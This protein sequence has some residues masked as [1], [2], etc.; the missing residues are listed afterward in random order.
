M[1]SKLI[2]IFL[3]LALG[4]LFAGIFSVP[5]RKI[6]YIYGK[7]ISFLRRRKKARNILA[8]LSWYGFLL[9]VLFSIFGLLYF[10]LYRY[11]SKV[12]WNA[13]L[14]MVTDTIHRI[15]D[16]IPIISMDSFDSLSSD[17]VQSIMKLPGMIG[18]I[19]IAILISVYLLMD[20]DDYMRNL[21][22]WRREYLSFKTNRFLSA[23]FRETKE[24]LFSYLKGQSLD[25]LVMGILLSIGLWMVKV[26]LGI[27]I[28][29]LAGI[30]NIIPYAGPVIA[31]TLTILLCL[32]EQ[33]VR[34]LITA[35]IYLIL[36][37]QLDSSF[38]GPK[39]LGKQMDVRPLFVIVSI[40]VGGTLF[41][42]IGMI[43]A[44][45][46]AAILK[47]LLKNTLSHL[48]GKII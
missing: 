7:N 8:V 44:V 26:P 36:I 20:W 16:F 38:I 22:K 48:H 33:R 18:K 21:R 34:T 47:S 6:N 43:F 5:V 31:F 17:I 39:L 32:I 1:F 12:S 13:F 15:F 9:I 23:V 19:V 46:A 35:I 14:M 42:I 24:N 2:H 3:I 40:L 30:G 11:F 28:G 29:I 4:V 27:P 25:A 37:Q 45:P 10:H 41:G